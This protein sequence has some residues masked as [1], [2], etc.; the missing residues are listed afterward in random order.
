M[1]FQDPMTSLNPV[2]TVGD[3][4]AE[5]IKLHNTNYLIMRLRKGRTDAGTVGIPAARYENILTNFRA[6]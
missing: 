5:V 1:I 4:I 2:V 3:Q 6:V